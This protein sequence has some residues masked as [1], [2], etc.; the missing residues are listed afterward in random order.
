MTLSKKLITALLFF[1]PLLIG[2]KTNFVIPNVVVVQGGIVLMSLA[3]LLAMKLPI[4]VGLFYIWC[5]ITTFTS[6]TP[7][8][9]GV[10][11]FFVTI[12]VL[13]YRNL[14]NAKKEDLLYGCKVI[15]LVCYI[16]FFWVLLQWLN[17]DFLITKIPE[18]GRVYGTMG[19][20]TLLGNL[21]LLCVVPM[22]F[23]KKWTTVFPI[24]GALI[25]GTSGAVYALC[26]GVLFYLLFSKL[27]YKL[28]LIVMLVL[29]TLSLCK[30]YESPFENT[31]HGRVLIGKDIIKSRSETNLLMGEGLGTFKFKFRREHPHYLRPVARAHNI[32]L[33]VFYEQGLVGL[34]LVISIPLVLFIDFIKKRTN[35]LW[36]TAIVMICINGLVHF[37]C[38]NYATMYYVMFTFVCYQ[39][40]KEKIC[41]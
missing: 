21:F 22:F 9:S 6:S 23:H 39:K 13:L 32:F 2:I 14:L 11:F 27:K 8:L 41:H 29:A 38:R 30:F 4:V 33:Q 28:V 25:T 40:F 5:L 31:F 15:S 17:I 19:N 3:L 36:M 34:L 37:T 1:L 10:A 16:Q 20:S 7:E 26:G 12:F 18:M 35:L 24:T